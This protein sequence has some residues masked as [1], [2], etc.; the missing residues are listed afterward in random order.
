M[1]AFRVEKYTSTRGNF[2]CFTVGYV[3][4]ILKLLLCSSYQYMMTRASFINRVI[5]LNISERNNIMEGFTPLY[6]N[7]LC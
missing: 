6:K 7:S 2:L 3:K 4:R 5:K 1:N